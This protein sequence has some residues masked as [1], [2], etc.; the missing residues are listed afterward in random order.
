MKELDIYEML[1]SLGNY[2]KTD[3]D[4]K[5]DTFGSSVPD[6]LNRVTKEREGHN[7][8]VTIRNTAP[9]EAN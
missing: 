8:K 2:L 5:S 6:G 7:V 1:K 9:K 4:V 3:I